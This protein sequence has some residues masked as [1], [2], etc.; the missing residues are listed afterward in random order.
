MVLPP[1]ATSAGS[2]PVGKYSTATRTFQITST[3]K[4]PYEASLVLRHML[5]TD[6]AMEASKSGAVYLQ[7]EVLDSP[8]FREIYP[9]VSAEQIDA[10][11]SGAS[12]PASARMFAIVEVLEQ[13]MQ[14]II[15]NPNAPTEDL[16]K[17]WQA[18]LDNAGN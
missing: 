4:H 14:D 18:E 12:Q 7:N 15:N 10:F 6:V 5:E 2:A 1:L 8:E 13:M 9:F 11:Q 17:K 3:S 16:A